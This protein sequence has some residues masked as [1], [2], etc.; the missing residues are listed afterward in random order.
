MVDRNHRERARRLAAAASR[1]ERD[2]GDEVD[3]AVRHINHSRRRAGM[4][5]FKRF[6]E[7]YFAATFSRGGTSGSS[8]SSFGMPA[9]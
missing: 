2:V 6:C 5:S 3:A 9:E 7:F 1:A 4:K 8:I